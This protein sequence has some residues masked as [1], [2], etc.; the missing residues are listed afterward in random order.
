MSH[1]GKRRGETAERF[2]RCVFGSDRAFIL[3]AVRRY[4]RGKRFFSLSNPPHKHTVFSPISPPLPCLSLPSLFFFFFVVGGD[5]SVSTCG[6][7]V[8][9]VWLVTLTRHKASTEA[10]ERPGTRP[11]VSRCSAPSVKTALIKGPETRKRYCQ[12]IDLLE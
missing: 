4:L 9:L 1:A 3:A 5:V 2:L 11:I 10:D 6:R 12:D 7:P 8:L